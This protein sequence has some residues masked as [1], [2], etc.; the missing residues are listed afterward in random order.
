MS[1]PRG[2]VAAIALLCLTVLAAPPLA[3]QGNDTILLRLAG[4]DVTASTIIPPIVKR[5]LETR[6]ASKIGYVR[7]PPGWTS[8]IRGSLLRGARIAVLIRASNS[9]EGFRYLRDGRADIALAGRTIY[10]SEVSDLASL[11]DMASPAAAHEIALAAAVMTTHAN[12]S[13]DAIGFDQIRAVYQGRISDWSQ[14][15]GA[16][17]PI[18]PLG[19][20]EGAASRDVFDRTIMGTAR[21]GSGVRFF[22]TYKDLREALF[23][24]PDAIGYMPLGLNNGLRA[25]RLR[26]GR[27]LAPLPDEYGLTSGDYPFAL[28]IALYHAPAPKTASEEIAGFIHESK[29]IATKADLMFLD[30]FPVTPQLLIPETSGSD[31]A[32]YR[33]LALGLRVSTTIHFPA[34]STTID[35]FNSDTLD[36]LATYLRF[37]QAPATNVHF[38]AFSDDAGT[39][40]T[41]EAVARQLG[42][43]VREELDRRRVH[44]TEVREGRTHT[45][46]VLSLGA[47]A[48]LAS[49]FTPEGRYLNRRVETWITP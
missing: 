19:R 12:N 5:F 16:P 7:P 23:R 49:D 30:L 48:P 18:H 33:R 35:A 39:A 46:E 17:A 20:A 10:P 45:S 42:M 31:A 43:L 27:R 44:V 25:I 14:L 28:K 22:H 32:A 29:S 4:D 2:F 9:T 47:S 3:G 13:V 37:L 11:G 8:E 41:N 24:D 15:G 40:A 34:G 21:Y 26:I 36:E 38:V 1:R 6:G